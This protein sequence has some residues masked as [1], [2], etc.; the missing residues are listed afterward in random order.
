[1]GLDVDVDVDVGVVVVVLV[2]GGLNGT[3]KTKKDPEVEI[4]RST[5][6]KAR[7]C[8]CNECKAR[9]NEQDKADRAGHGQ[10][11]AGQGQPQ[12]GRGSGRSRGRIF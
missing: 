6:F 5:S 2:L 7:Q 9:T 1:L 10:D 11:G 12:I 3:D 8:R 4:V